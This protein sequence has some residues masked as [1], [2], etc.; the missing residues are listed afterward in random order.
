MDN[1]IYTGTIG[2]NPIVVAVLGIALYLLGKRVV[3]P[4]IVKAEGCPRCSLPA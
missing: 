2:S 3:I 1:G 4:R